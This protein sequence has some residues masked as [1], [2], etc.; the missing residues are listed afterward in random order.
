MVKVYSFFLG[1][2]FIP[3]LCSHGCKLRGWRKVFLKCHV[4]LKTSALVSLYCSEGG[5]SA[6]PPR[7]S[8]AACRRDRSLLPKGFMDMIPG[9][10]PLKTD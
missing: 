4:I 1:E 8:G 9:I 5:K 3:Q 7:K 6:L 10:I 2:N